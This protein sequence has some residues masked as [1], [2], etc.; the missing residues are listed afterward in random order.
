MTDKQPL[1]VA[2]RQGHD[3]ITA[4]QRRSLASR[5]RILRD[6]PAGPGFHRLVQRPR[7]EHDTTLSFNL[8]GHVQ[9]HRLKQLVRI[10]RDGPERVG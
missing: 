10:A 3:Q 8:I 4:L 6:D 7:L 5:R 1:P 2:S 9:R